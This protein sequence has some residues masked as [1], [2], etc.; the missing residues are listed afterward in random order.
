MHCPMKNSR[1]IVSFLAIFWPSMALLHLAAQGT[2]PAQLAVPAGLHP[3]AIPEDNPLTEGKV[4]LG[5]QLFFDPRLS[6]DDSVSCSTCHDSAKGWSNGSRFG[7]GVDG[8]I[9][10]RHVPSL[11]NAAY[12]KYLFWDGRAKSLEQ[13]SRGPIEHE[14]EMGLPMDQL[15]TKLIQISDYR[16]Q[17]E[18]VFGGEATPDRIAKSIAS[19]ERT[20]V[21]GNAPYDRFRAGDLKALS[22]AA[23][24]GHQVFFFRSNCA[25]CHIG[26]TFS[27]GKFHNTGIG[28]DQSNPDLGRFFV[29]HKS[30][31][32][33]GAFKTPTLRDISRTAPYMHD[34]SLKSLAEVVEFYSDGGKM[35]PYLDD[36]ITSLLMTEQQKADLVV[37]LTEG[38]TSDTYPNPEP[39]ELPE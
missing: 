17:F 32:D 1:N 34:G 14:S 21:A 39:P 11:V 9:G 5:K 22:P 19:F 7:T 10:S 37:F 33:R 30:D 38:L 6:R 2:P 25:F 35:N 31:L 24:R 27:D 12:Q 28:M 18:A 23:Q 8:R 36:M 20:L 15:A 4:K 16:R 13:Q 26:P 29:N 3:L